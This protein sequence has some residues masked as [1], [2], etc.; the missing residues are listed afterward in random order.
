MNKPKGSCQGSGTRCQLKTKN[1]LVASWRL[2]AGFLILLLVAGCSKGKTDIPELS[3]DPVTASVIVKDLPE[4]VPVYGIVAGGALE[5]NVEKE[6]A[7]RVVPGQKAMAVVGSD[8]APVE[9]R[10][11]NILPNANLATGMAI[12]WLRPVMKTSLPAG[13]FVSAQIILRIKR[14]VPTVPERAVFIR[15][16]KTMVILRQAGKDKDAE[17]QYEPVQVQTGITSDKDVEILSGL[18]P[19]DQVV[20]QAGIGFLY[21]EFQSQTGD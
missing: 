4:T 12:A 21:P 2:A 20:V 11:A 18:K 9:F 19:N 6:D 5:V 8:K 3:D 1:P 10:V 7:P 17:A 13:D 15:D 14:G 16:G